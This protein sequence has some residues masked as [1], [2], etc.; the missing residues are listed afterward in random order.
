M[1]EGIQIEAKKIALLAATAAEEKKAE[2][3]V[4]LDMREVITFTDYFFICSAD[5]TIQAQA[6][7][8]SIREQLEKSGISVWHLEG[9]GEGKWILLDYGDVIMHIFLEE[10]R[11]FYNLERLWG[12]AKVLDIKKICK[13]EKLK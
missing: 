9:Y 5:S 4:I 11:S 12:D 7:S 3:I 13:K 8:Q 10:P 2:N 1:E 6:I